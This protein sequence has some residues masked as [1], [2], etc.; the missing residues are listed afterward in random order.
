MCMH[1]I[2]LFWQYATWWSFSPADKTNV[3]RKY[4]VTTDYALNFGN[5]AITRLDGSRVKITSMIRICGELGFILF[6]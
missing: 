2:G 5:L 6:L 1:M 3:Y 4:A